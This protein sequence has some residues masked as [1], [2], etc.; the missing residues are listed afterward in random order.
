MNGYADAIVLMWFLPVT[1]FVVLPL[2]M[3]CCR[4]IW[5]LVVPKRS[6]I[7]IPEGATP[8]TV[9]PEMLGTAGA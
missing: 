7:S 3:L 4:L 8:R 5:R 9:S 1:L 2:T 6:W